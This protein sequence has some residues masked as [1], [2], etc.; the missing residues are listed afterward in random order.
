M[1]NKSGRIFTTIQCFENNIWSVISKHHS[2]VSNIL[3]MEII[4]YIKCD[5]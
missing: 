2:K 1:T 5:E 3:H 4:G